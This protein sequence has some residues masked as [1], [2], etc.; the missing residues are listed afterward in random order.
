MIFPER[1]SD[2]R[3][4]GAVER[5]SSSSPGAGRF[6]PLSPSSGLFSSP[7]LAAMVSRSSPVAAVWDSSAG[8]VVLAPPARSTVTRRDSVA[9]LACCWRASRSAA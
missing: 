1:L 7:R 3:F 4:V 2:L 9:L 6:S 8:P 5:F